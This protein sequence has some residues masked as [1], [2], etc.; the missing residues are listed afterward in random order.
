MFKGFQKP[1][2]LV[3]NTE[4]LTDRY[5]AFTAQPFERGF[6]ST[7]GVGLRRILL[8][9]IDGAA[10]TAVRIEGAASENASIP[11]VVEDATDIILNLKQVPFRTSSDE[12]HTVKL[13]SDKA[14]ELLSGQIETSGA[15]AEG[16]PRLCRERPQPRRRSAGRLHR[17]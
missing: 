16:R 9:A 7:I 12:L 11:G 15:A 6:G 3:A 17:H 1:K 14:G 4:T 2:R 13:T 5:G 10:I 8:S